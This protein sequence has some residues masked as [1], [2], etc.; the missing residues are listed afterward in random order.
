MSH[1]AFLKR[2]AQDIFD[3]YDIDLDQLST[4]N[5][6]L[7]NNVRR[8]YILYT[9]LG[10]VIE[11]LENNTSNLTMAQLEKERDQLVSA[12]DKQGK[13]TKAIFQKLLLKESAKNVN[14]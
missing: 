5:Q 7:N 3:I 12:M 10:H 13:K 1:K 14:K 4:S 11:L 8:L 2:V 6:T 9:D